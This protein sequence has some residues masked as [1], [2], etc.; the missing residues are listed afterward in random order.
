MSE[1]GIVLCGG[2]SSRMG[3]AKALMPF[4]RERLIE[5]VVRLLSAAVDT[6]VVVAAADQELPELPK[7]VVVARDEQPFRGPLS[8]LARGLAV[9]EGRAELAYLTG[10]DVPFLAP[11]FVRRMIE[12]SRDYD[13]AVPVDLS[14]AAKLYHPL[15]A[16][17]RATVEP[18]MAELLAADRLRLADLFARV[19]TREA[20][21]AELQECDPGLA[22]LRNLNHPHEYL[23]ALAEAGFGG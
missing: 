8:G 11:A 15:A 13:A 9:L 17:Y 20:T 3:A 14:G 16:V 21:L 12:L 6:I 1:A 23:A 4:G 7:Q 18:Q 2:R 19:R 10:C 22:S 5:R